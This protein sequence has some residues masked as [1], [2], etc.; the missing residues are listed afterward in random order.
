MKNTRLFLLLL[1]LAGWQSA[2]A[3]A[4]GQR[5]TLRYSGEPLG[6]VLA[7]ISH[8]YDVRFSYSPDFIPLQQRISLKVENEPLSVALDDICQQAPLAYAAM[9]GQVLLKPDNSR[10]QLGQLETRKPQVTQNS[11]IYPEP[12]DPRQQAE[13]E[14]LEKLLSPIGENQENRVIKGGG[15]SY[16]EV[17]L[18]TYRLPA[19]PASGRKGDTRLAQISL[20][21]YIGTN[22][23]R[24]NEITNKVSVNLLWGTN[25][26]VD[27]LEVGGLVNSVKNDVNGVQVA[28]LGSLVG[29]EVKGTQVGGF[30]NRNKGMTTGVQVAGLINIAEEATAVQTALGANVTNGDFAGVQAAGFFNIAGGNADGLQVSG[31]FNYS[32]GAVKTQVSSLF[33]KAGDVEGAQ[34]SL[35]F[36]KAKRVDGFQF[37]L[38][39]VSDTIN[40]VPLGLL[41]I[42]RHGYNR[43]EISTSDALYANVG[44]KLGARSFYNIFQLG[45]RWDDVPPNTNARK[46]SWGLGYGLGSAITIN[47]RLLL[48]I[49]AV[50]MQINEQ[51][52]WTREVNLLNQLRLT[53]DFHK[54][55]KRT[56]FF[57][58][59]VGN[60]LVSR[61]Q[62]AD[63][64]VIGSRVIRPS[65]TLLDKT[66]DKTNT[67]LWIGLQAGVRF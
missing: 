11:P 36:N 17:S 64:G 39:N 14:R 35:L 26:G 67:K 24:S 37:G 52:R 57:V 12:M 2:E 28:G 1:I 43:I 5:V 29:G 21:P 18:D 62:D 48:N 49:E 10:Q 6:A 47:P 54:P 66:G 7:D 32:G 63:S 23:L 3:Q 58:G 31:L 9:G 53:L 41:N 13:R 34:A 22:A 25:G 38:V 46:M 61:I 45:A 42:V 33:N 15:Y 55:G 60:L 65:Y 4:L 20:L 50:A 16:K 19:E 40:G 51:E 44:L 30:F 56:S 8:S 27:G 59:P